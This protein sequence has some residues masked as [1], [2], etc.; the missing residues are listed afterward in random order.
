MNKKMDLIPNDTRINRVILKRVIG[1]VIV[2]ASVLGGVLLMAVYMQ[3]QVLWL[4]SRVLSLRQQVNALEEWDQGLAP[5]ADSL[6]T[7][8]GCQVVVNELLNEP[9]W[10]GLLA[11]LSFASRET[12]WLNQFTLTK[13]EV[14]MPDGTR[15]EVALMVVSGLASSD[16]E[17]MRFITRFSDSEHLTSLTL[18]QATIPNDTELKDMREFELHGTVQWRSEQ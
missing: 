5:L 4:D 13:D 15:R 3:R 18:A 17:L 12:L 8:Y 2:S 6:S 10:S 1:W 14:S 11:D 9:F 16:K 7:A